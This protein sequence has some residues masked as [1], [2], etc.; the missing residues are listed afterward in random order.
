MGNLIDFVQ[1]M[2]PSLQ[3]KL[4][5]FSCLG[6][7]IYQQQALF[8]NAFRSKKWPLITATVTTSSFDRQGNVYAPLIVYRYEYLGQEHMNDTYSYLG[9]T[10]FT[11]KSAIKTA[12]CF[13]KG[14]VFDVHVDPNDPA[15]ST[16]VPGI[17][18]TQ[19][20]SWIGVVVFFL[21]VAF[22]AEIFML[23]E[24]FFPDL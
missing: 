11:K 4:L 9:S 2:G 12:Q 17:H 24:Y 18:W 5:M 3:L 1:S 23:L 16:I 20:A 10:S 6:Y 15:N 7:M 22:L 8:V 14:H 13:P 21:S 19:A